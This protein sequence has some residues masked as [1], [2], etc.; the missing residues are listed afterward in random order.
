MGMVGLLLLLATCWALHALKSNIP[1]I[2]C[3]QVCS[4]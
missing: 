4:S 2:N 3:L 1:L